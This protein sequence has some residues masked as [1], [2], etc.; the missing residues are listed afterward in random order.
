MLNKSIL[1]LL[2]LY[3]KSITL[4]LRFRLSA[5]VQFATFGATFVFGRNEM[6]DFGRSLYV[7]Y[8]NLLINAVLELQRNIGI[9]FVEVK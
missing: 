1:A 8:K 6:N 9:L 5:K 4:S 7:A 2:T 3:G